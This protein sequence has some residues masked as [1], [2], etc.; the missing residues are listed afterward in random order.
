MHAD[1]MGAHMSIMEFVLNT[2]EESLS[3]TSIKSGY[4]IMCVETDADG[5]GNFN[6][7]CHIKSKDMDMDHM[8]TTV[9]VSL[10]PQLVTSKPHFYV[11]D[12]S[13]IRK[14]VKK[15][16]SGSMYYGNVAGVR[17]YTT[18][19]LMYHVEY[20]KDGDSEDLELNQFSYLITKL[21]LPIML[22]KKTQ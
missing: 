15:R 12:F 22:H 19:C 10:N 1:S 18:K 11:V 7:W 4:L 2:A 21:L 9:L 6:I 8:L 13:H 3:M 20:S 16:F 17:K 5:A 14:I